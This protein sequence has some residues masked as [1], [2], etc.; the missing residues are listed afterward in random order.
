MNA[1]PR[2]RRRKAD[3]PGEIV[4]AA[5]AVF[6]ERGFAAARI[7]EIAARAGLSKGAIYRYFDTK[8]ALFRAVVTDA[9]RPNVRKV[10]DTAAAWQGGVPDLVRMLLPTVA[11]LA[12]KLPVG[13]VLKMVIGESRNF[14]ELA[15][16]WHDE[17]VQP[18]LS[19]L[20]RLIAEGQARGELRPGDPRTHAF[21]LM[22]P[23]LLGV[24]WRETFTPLGAGDVDLPAVARQH[25]ETVLAGMETRR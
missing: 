8:E 23:M 17:V 25:V 15:R 11:G 22:A 2:W 9:V 3:R 16:V 5:I 1:E 4:A 10:L 21:S 19:L 7:D 18:A 24:I 13:A 14:P 20:M 6:T 12:M